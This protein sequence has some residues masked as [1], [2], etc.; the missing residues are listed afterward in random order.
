MKVGFQISNIKFPIRG[1]LAR[2]SAALIALATSSVAIAQTCPACYNNAAAQSPGL[3]HA[4]KTGILVMMFPTVIMFIVIFTV[5]Y[6][7][8]NT[9][10]APGDE[11]TDLHRDSPID[12]PPSLTTAISKP[13]VWL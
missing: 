12:L 3:L 4:L 8:R 2:L 10:H 6:R 5:L 9:F 1:F 13:R 11:E 7:R